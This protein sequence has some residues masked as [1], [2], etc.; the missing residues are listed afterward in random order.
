MSCSTRTCQILYLFCTFVFPTLTLADPPAVSQTQPKESPTAE[1]PAATDAAPPVDWK[2]FP[3]KWTACQ[4]GGDG[5]VVIEAKQIS[6]RLGDPLTGVYLKASDDKQTLARDHYELKLRARRTDG[7]DFFCGLTFPVAKEHTTLVLGG[8]GG[9][10]TG[11]SSLD[12]RDASENETSMYQP[13]KNDQWYEIRVRVDPFAVQCW[14]DNESIV[15]VVRAEHKFGLRFEMELCEP[16]GIAAYQCAAE[17]QDIVWRT[18]TDAEL[19]EARAKQKA[20]EEE[21]E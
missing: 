7:F 1:I 9:G 12:G 4:F 16:L 18:L 13:Y 2:P 3:G 21:D 17:Y 10:I 8:W 6:V 11:L 15:D 5:K 14:I 20:W 19:A